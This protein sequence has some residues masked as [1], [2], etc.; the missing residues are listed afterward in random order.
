MVATIQ[1]GIALGSTAG[2][3][4]FDVNGYQST[5]AASAGVLLLAA[6]LAVMTSRS[7]AT[8]QRATTE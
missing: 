5:F 1:S 4:L 8:W 3:L 6:F 2:W 7:Q